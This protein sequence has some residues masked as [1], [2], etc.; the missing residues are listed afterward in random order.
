MQSM[1]FALP[2][3]VASQLRQ[4]VPPEDQ[5]EVV[6]EALRMTLALRRIQ[7][8]SDAE[9]MASCEALNSDPHIAQLERDMDALSGDGLD[10]Y[11]WDQSASR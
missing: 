2:D 5:A 8:S 4:T 11:P 9:L 10:E 1:T 3:D 6:A 7:Q